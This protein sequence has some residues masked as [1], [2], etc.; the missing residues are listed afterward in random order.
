MRFRKYSRKHAFNILFQWDI[1]G[2]N[3]NALAQSYWENLGKTYERVANIAEDLLSR[4]DGEFDAEVYAKKFEQFADEEILADKLRKD[5]YAVYLLL[6]SLEEFHNFAL[7]YT[8]WLSERNKRRRQKAFQLLSEIK[9]LINGIGGMEDENR[10]IV[11]PLEKFLDELKESPPQD[12]GEIKLKEKEYKRLVKEALKD[13][14]KRI[15]YFTKKRLEEDLGEIKEYAER[16]LKS[17]DEHK[18]EVDS[19]I[20]E[21]LK[22]W[23]LDSLGTVER[24]LLRLGA[25][26]FMFVGVQDPGRAF[27]DYIDFA[28]AYVGKKAAKFVNGVLS[29]IFNKKVK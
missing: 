13:F 26:E 1:T 24:N 19:T 12:F 20:E 14:L 2:E 18:I 17:Y 10:Q 3:L 6:K 16:L 23:S 7:T 8:G 25:A 29:S 15:L 28:K 21:F 5:L 22:D 27:N 9:K 4:L 11:N